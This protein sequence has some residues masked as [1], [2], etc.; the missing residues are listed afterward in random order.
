[1][2]DR[3]SGLTQAS[4]RRLLERSAATRPITKRFTSDRPLITT[5]IPTGDYN[6]DAGVGLVDAVLA[7]QGSG[8][9]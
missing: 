4:V 8:A 7:V 5:P 3:N 2:L 9:P 6:Y 1:M